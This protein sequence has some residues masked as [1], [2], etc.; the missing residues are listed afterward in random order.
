MDHLDCLG[1]SLEFDRLVDDVELLHIDTEFGAGLTDKV[2]VTYESNF[3]E[4]HLGSLGTG[5]DGVLIHGPG[6]D[7]LLADT[8]FL[9]FCK[10]VCE[11]C[12]HRY[13]VI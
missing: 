9:E 2:L 1:D 8:L 3:H 12:N 11:F 6:R 7:H 13:A 10:Y 4:S 5:L